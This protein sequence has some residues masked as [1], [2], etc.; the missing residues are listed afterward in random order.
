MQRLAEICDHNAT[1]VPFSS[2]R[3]LMPS[4]L[5]AELSE[6]LPIYSPTGAPAAGAV[7]VAGNYIT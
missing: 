7:C 5:F 4:V 2:E 1:C 6:V 3:I